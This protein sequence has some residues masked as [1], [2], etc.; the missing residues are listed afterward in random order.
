M[1]EK[2]KGSDAI[3]T[4]LHAVLQPA[5][6]GGLPEA[7]AEEL[8]EEILS[9]IANLGTLSDGLTAFET[10]RDDLLEKWAMHY[11]KARNDQPA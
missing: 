10:L 4:L 6:A 3:S 1:S 9:S 11:L 8:Y 5:I 2:M 7:R